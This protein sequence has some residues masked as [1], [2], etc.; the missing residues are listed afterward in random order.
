[1]SKKIKTGRPAKEAY[2]KCGELCASVTAARVHCSGTANAARKK[3]KAIAG[4]KGRRAE[5][6][7]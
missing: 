7:K 5:T 4:G 3:Q 6:G 1:M 2:C